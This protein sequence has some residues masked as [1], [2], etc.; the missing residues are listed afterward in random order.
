M[1]ST[2]DTR[3]QKRRTDRHK[4]RVKEK[5]PG[6]IAMRMKHV[7]RLNS[8]Q[9]SESRSLPSKQLH[10]DKKINIKLIIST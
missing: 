3:R 1:M 7:R 6:R 2:E 8:A 9:V 10:T 5:P 4:T